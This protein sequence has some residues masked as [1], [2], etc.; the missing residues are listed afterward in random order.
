MSL[1]AVSTRTMT[2]VEAVAIRVVTMTVLLNKFTD[3]A[4]DKSPCECSFYN[5]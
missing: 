1:N 5:D 4:S 3:P 2:P